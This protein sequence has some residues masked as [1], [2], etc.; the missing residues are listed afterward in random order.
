MI[1]KIEKVGGEEKLKSVKRIGNI[2]RSLIE[3]FRA[4]PGH[5]EGIQNGP[6][7]RTLKLPNHPWTWTITQ[8][9]ISP[10]DG[11]WNRRSKAGL[12]EYI[13]GKVH[14]CHASL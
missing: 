13:L 3:V 14:N 12:F 4:W 5:M 9:G 7:E 2:L 10:N 11:S 6:V 1:W 8:S